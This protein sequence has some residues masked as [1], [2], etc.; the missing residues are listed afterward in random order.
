TAVDFSISFWCNYTNQIDDP[1]FI[2]NKDWG[3]SNNQGWGIFTQGGGNFRVNVTDDTGA[4]GKQDTTSTPNIRDGKW[5]HVMVTFA[6]QSV[7][8]IYVDGTQATTS[9]LTTVA[10]SIDSGLGVNIGQDGTGAYTDGGSAEMVN[11]LMD[12]LGIW[13]RVVSAGEVA[14]I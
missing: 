12:D 11:V 14:A 8:T 5:H 1:P 4:S 7:A 3:S 13:R 2:A 9:P 10:G 6:R